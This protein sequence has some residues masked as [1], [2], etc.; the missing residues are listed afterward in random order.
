MRAPGEFLWR[1]SADELQAMANIEQTAEQWFT[2]HPNA[3]HVVLNK[4][5]PE[6]RAVVPRVWLEVVRRARA[7]GWRAHI[8]GRRVVVAKPRC[9]R[10]LGSS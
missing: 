2:D 3:G 1:P 4:D 9:D 5:G 8:R 7:A 6:H 10:S